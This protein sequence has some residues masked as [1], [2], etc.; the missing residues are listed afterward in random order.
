MQTHYF[1]LL[2]DF[3]GSSAF[4]VSGAMVAAGQG[5]DIFGV[6]ILAVVTA[7]GGGFIRDLII[8]Q[9]PPLMFLDP[10]Y[11]IL[12]S[13]CAVAVFVVL[14]IHK[15]SGRTVPRKFHEIYD[16]AVFLCDALGLAAFTVDGLS[17]GI[18][19]GY[20]YNTFLLIFLSVMTGVGGGVIRDVLAMKMPYI[21]T[22]HVYAVAS[23]AGAAGMILVIKSGLSINAA[24][25][26]GFLLTLVIRLLAR[27]YEWNLPRIVS[28][29]DTVH[30]SATREQ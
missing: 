4:A 19:A 23:L 17:A 26:T 3:I 7:T 9:N 28:I 15:K 6:I 25:M 27:H 13:A 2:M 8:D 29:R 24:I 21:F 14:Y 30:G 10:F 20:S 16:Y 5:M 18:K 1:I 11:V 22:K 12:A